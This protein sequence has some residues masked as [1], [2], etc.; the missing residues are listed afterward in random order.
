MAR[1]FSTRRRSHTAQYSIFTVRVAWNRTWKP[2]PSSKSNQKIKQKL[3]I[4]FSSRCWRFSFW[5]FDCFVWVFSIGYR[6]FYTKFPNVAS[7]GTLAF[8]NGFLVMFHWQEFAHNIIWCFFSPAAFDWMHQCVRH[9]KHHSEWQTEHSLIIS[10]SPIRILLELQLRP[11]MI[12][13]QMVCA[14]LY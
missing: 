9:T 7:I 11:G 10:I 12:Q 1:I 2:T 14:Q 5:L 6:F 13:I 3:I 8:I 4:A